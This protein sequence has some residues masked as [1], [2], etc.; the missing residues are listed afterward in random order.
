MHAIQALCAWARLEKEL[1]NQNK[2]KTQYRKASLHKLF[3]SI[4]R[5]HHKVYVK[6]VGWVQIDF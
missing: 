2:P 6:K 5:K 1:S 4:K 3:P